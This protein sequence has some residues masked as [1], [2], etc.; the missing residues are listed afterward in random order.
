[1]AFRRT[2]RNAGLDAD[3]I[4]QTLFPDDQDNSDTEMMNY[5]SESEYE[6]HHK[7]GYT[8]DYLEDEEEI[9]MD[10]QGD[11]LSEIQPGDP[12]GPLIDQ[13][14]LRG[15]RTARRSSGPRMIEMPSEVSGA[16][17]A[18]TSPEPA[19]GQVQESP[20]V[21]AIAAIES[22]E[23]TSPARSPARTPRSPYFRPQ[24][25]PQTPHTGAGM[26]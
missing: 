17:P 4:L 14:H 13:S 19:R 7:D 22:P 23:P 10:L 15:R 8:R 6:Y 16:A 18:P 11:A 20:H 21:A 12:L 9:I 26:C 5:S 1:M 2:G 24:R 3:G 25:T